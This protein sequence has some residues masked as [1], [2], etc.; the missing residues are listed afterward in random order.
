MIGILVWEILD[1]SLLLTFSSIGQTQTRVCSLSLWGEPSDR[2]IWIM[3]LLMETVNI[4]AVIRYTVWLLIQ[5]GRKIIVLWVEHD[6]IPCNGNILDAIKVAWMTLRVVV[7][8]ET[9]FDVGVASDNETNFERHSM[10]FKVHS[11][12]TFKNL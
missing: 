8:S 3:A 10:I 7:A 6:L 11:H 12:S 1:P 2:I 5:S 9:M 4:C